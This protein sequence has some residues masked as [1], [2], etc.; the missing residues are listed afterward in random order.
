MEVVLY[1][2]DDGSVPVLEW[3]DELPQ[4]IQDKWAARIKRLMDC[5]HE[6]RRPEADYLKD[7]IY[8][9]RVR[10][11]RVNYRLLYF[12][13]GNRIVVL[14]HGLIKGREVP[15]KQI[16]KALEARRRFEAGP[17]WHTVVWEP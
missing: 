1:K 15:A 6:L 16:E 10:Y 4:K 2:E 17:E 5:G 3:L 8:E 12:F 13:F 9:L 11:Q 7:G 14:T